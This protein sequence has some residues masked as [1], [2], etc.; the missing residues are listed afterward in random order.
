VASRPSIR[1][2]PSLARVVVGASVEAGSSY[3][4]VG[5]IVAR[6]VVG[7]QPPS[8]IVEDVAGQ[9][10]EF[11]RKLL[12]LSD[13]AVGVSIVRSDARP[14]VPTPSRPSGSVTAKVVSQ[15]VPGAP[16]LRIERADQ[17]TLQQ[18]YEALIAESTDV[19][20]HE[21]NHPAY[22]RVISELTPD[23]ARIL[24]LFAVDGPQPALDI[25]T[26]GTFGFGSRLV[27]PGVT[28]IGA[29]AGCQEPD[30][31][32]SYLN[33]LNR[34]GLIWFSREM[35]GDVNSYALLEAQPDVLEAAEELGGKN[36]IRNTLRSIELTAFG[37]NLCSLCGLLPAGELQTRASVGE[38]S[39]RLP[40]P[41]ER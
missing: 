17:R 24:R 27:K 14:P 1:S 5:V 36:R 33:N 29:Y 35:I 22:V 15:P 25:R 9:A 11:A 34:L 40:A 28:M 2:I 38:I 3:V 30:R 13:E 6:G 8:A 26:A 10:T 31:V 21:E 19:H 4:K 37:K 39:R 12:E 23:E 32:P 7:R 20:H 41:D 18:M 16:W